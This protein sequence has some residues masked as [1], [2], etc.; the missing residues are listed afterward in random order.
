MQENTQRTNAFGSV[1][2]IIVL[3]L[4][5]VAAGT[6]TAA[7]HVVKM[8]NE[9]DSGQMVFE[10][11]F[12][13]VDVGD[14]VVFTPEQAGLHNTHATFMP[15]GAEGW[16]SEPDTEF[17]VT[18]S[19]EGVYLYVCQPHVVF[20]MVGVIQAGEAVN[21]DAAAEAVAAANSELAMNPDRFNE[22]FANVE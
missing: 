3:T 13:K 16:T 9:G 10:P 8:L 14:T 4:T 6:A 15:E 7:E 20:G 21:K 5:A 11:S 22:A 19:T 12:L 18:L 1:F 2:K 17:K